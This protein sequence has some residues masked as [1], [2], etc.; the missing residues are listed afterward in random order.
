[1][2]TAEQVSKNMEKSNGSQDSGFRQ[3]RK[4]KQRK[5]VGRD[6]KRIRGGLRGTALFQETGS[7][8][9]QQSSRWAE[10][11]N[12]GFCR[13]LD[14]HDAEDD[15]ASQQVRVRP[16]E[17]ATHSRY[18]HGAMSAV[19]AAP[20]PARPG[21]APNLRRSCR[22][23]EGRR[24]RSTARRAAAATDCSASPS[25]RH[26]RRVRSRSRT[27]RP[28]SPNQPHLTPMPTPTQPCGSAAIRPPPRL[29][30]CAPAPARTRAGCA[31]CG[32]ARRRRPLR[33]GRPLR[34][35][36]CRCEG[37]IELEK[38]GVETWCL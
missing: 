3:K 32:K 9:E 23:S 15:S 2:I 35:L 34:E 11:I 5:S 19:G 22:R 18:H 25:T 28:P 37:R 30:P 16:I 13:A 36:K 38:M 8:S 27:R 24:S 29:A 7:N 20:A 31:V 1:M 4:Y 26:R 12:C 17:V 21:K 6:N 33:P 14:R 10:P